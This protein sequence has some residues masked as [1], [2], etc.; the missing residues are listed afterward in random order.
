MSTYVGIHI[1]DQSLQSQLMQVDLCSLES[2][3]NS[4]KNQNGKV[5]AGDLPP[6]MVK[7]KAFREMY[8]EEEIRGILSGLDFDF[9]DEI[10]LN[11]SL[12]VLSGWANAFAITLYLV[13]YS[14]FSSDCS[15]RP[16]RSHLRNFT[17]NGVITHLPS[18]SGSPRRCSSTS[19]TSPDL[20]SPKLSRSARYTTKTLSSSSTNVDLFS[21]TLILSSLPSSIPTPNSSSSASPDAFVEARNRSRNVNLALEL[22]RKCI[23]LLVGTKE[24]R[25]EGNFGDFGEGEEAVFWEGEKAWWRGVRVELSVQHV[26][27]RAPRKLWRPNPKAELSFEN[28]GSYVYDA[29]DFIMEHGVALELD[30]P[31]NKPS[32]NEHGPQILIHNYLF[33]HG[34]QAMLQTLNTTNTSLVV[35]FNVDASLF[36]Y[37]KVSINS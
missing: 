19:T 33:A 26:V 35:V 37:E 21:P 8:S 29:F 22:V 1:T 14:P 7:L 20:R 15:C 13:V 32:I 25:E 16:L 3:F 9:S 17:A 23:R 24:R 10:D 6:L 28:E 4:L 18:L 27:D 11:P 30:W 12:R 2:K 36:D 5:M 31:Y 34:R